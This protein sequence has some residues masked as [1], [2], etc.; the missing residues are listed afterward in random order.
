[1]MYQISDGLI[2]EYEEILLGNRKSFSQALFPYSKKG[3]QKLA[4]ELMR[5]AIDHYLGW[6]PEEVRDYMTIDVIDSLKLRRVLNRIEFPSH[7][8]KNKD[9]F[10][11]AHML[12]PERIQYN[13]E[14]LTVRVMEQVAS[15]EL[16]KYPK[17]FFVGID[18]LYRAFV[19]VHH[20]IDKEVHVRNIEEL[21]EFFSDGKKLR[22]VI[23]KYKFGNPMNDLFMTP[24]DM[25]HESLS[26]GQ[27]NEFWYHFY[28]FK[29]L[30]KLSLPKEERL[31]QA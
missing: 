28:K 23:R 31:V 17:G 11:L 18:G 5:Y 3:N 9:M 30:S 24:V 2:A 14:D 6:T 20:M 27:K 12:Y 16:G 22:P 4:L 29:Y 1:M 19:C 13:E 25:L 7:I 26:S 15:G 21:Y 10:Y 8:D